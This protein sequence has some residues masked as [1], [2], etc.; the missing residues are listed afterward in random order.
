MRLPPL[1]AVTA[2]LVVGMPSGAYAHAFAQRYDLPLPLSYWLTG[3]GAA[4]ALS[5]VAAALALSPQAKDEHPPAP[6]ESDTLPKTGLARWLRSTIRVLAVVLFIA[7]IASGLI[8]PQDEPQD[9]VLP[10]T[11]W[12]LW[13]VGL[14]VLVALVGDVWS[15]VNP[16]RILAEWFVGVARKL[17]FPT[18]R[19]LYVLPA[20][21]GVWPAVG[22]FL[23]FAWAELVWTGNGVPAKLA[24]A[25]L[26][27]SAL[28]WVAMAAF[29]IR[30]WLDRGEAFSLFFALIGRYAVFDLRKKSEPARRSRTRTTLPARHASQAAF[31][32]VVLA[33]VS[34]D[35]LK[36]TP[37]WDALVGGAMH[38]LYAAGLVN[39]MGNVA[40]ES[41]VKTAG[42]LLMPVLMLAAYWAT[43]RAMAGIVGQRAGPIHTQWSTRTIAL[44]FA[45]SLVPIA[46]GYHVAHYFSYL[47]IQG[48]WIIPAASDPFGLGWN[49]FGTR[50][51]EPD[52]A[53]VGA[54][55]VW[56]IALA[57]IVTG[58]IA[59]VLLAHRVALNLFGDGRIALA[60][61]APMVVLMVGYT[62]LSLWILAQP[63]VSH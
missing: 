59:A 33:S 60:S 52:I 26:F 61:Q 5:F 34:F 23:A 63:I 4:V 55:V 50:G 58:H 6:L 54:G 28:T 29:G 36:E 1:R 13:W 3:A 49:L 31:N 45:G 44:A 56:W 14:T 27:Y 20:A 2:M 42:L 43:C 40:S 7:L 17:R 62:V 21:L 41:L 11:V 8:G 46:I 25:I 39:L 32:L 24:G 22:L 51:F 47:L 9:N 38:W 48:Q 15:T 30:T 10:I 53:I 37:F 19:P 18:D 57:A 16:L 35:G 12:V